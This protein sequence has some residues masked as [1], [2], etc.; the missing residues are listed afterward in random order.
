MKYIISETMPKKKTMKRR[1]RLWQPYLPKHV[2][3]PYP[4]Y[5]RI[6]ESGSL[7]QDLTGSW[8]ATHYESVRFILTDERFRS[9][10]PNHQFGDS[11]EFADEVMNAWILLWEGQV[12]KRL[13][14][15]ATKVIDWSGIESMVQE[16]VDDNLNALQDRTSLDAVK[17]IALLTP[18]HIITRILGLPVEDAPRCKVWA[19]ELFYV[20]N[21]YIT[22]QKWKRVVQNARE[23]THYLDA[24]IDQC[25]RENPNSAIVRLL[26]TPDDDGN[27]MDRKEVISFIIFLYTSGEETV[28]N[29]IGNAI[30]ALLQRPEQMQILRDDLN[31]INIATEELLRFDSSLQYSVRFAKTDTEL[32]GNKIKEGDMI[33]PVVGAANHDPEVFSNPMEINFNRK[34]YNHLT[35]GVGRHYCFGARLARI[36][37]R[38]V[39]K[40]FVEKLSHFHPD[41]NQKAIYNP[42]I[43][44]RGFKKLP[45]VAV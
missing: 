35:F 16:V 2:A 24:M 26:T 28:V 27:Y 36:E 45:L 23:F 40:G 10:V 14:G 44:L 21:P 39:I 17:D 1:E 3:N 9:N 19:G 31:L 38:A 8:I 15:I 13:R 25:T 20:I 41:P 42:N 22:P 43:M 4:M 34:K 5:D 11:A 29:F 30:Y 7:H 18:T 33:I 37:A 6:R 32:D 12:H